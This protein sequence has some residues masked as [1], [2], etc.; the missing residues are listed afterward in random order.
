MAF[1]RTVSLNDTAPSITGAGVKLS[2]PQSAE[3][4]EWAELRA[5]TAS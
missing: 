3:Y 4:P 2:R 1:F 5:P